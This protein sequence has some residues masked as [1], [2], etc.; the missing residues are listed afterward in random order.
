MIT[1]IKTCFKCGTEKTVA[2]FYKHPKMADGYLSKCKEC[3]K[4]D[5]RENRG[6]KLEYYREYDRS[7]GS[8]PTRVQ[9]RKEYAKTDACKTSVVKSRIRYKANNPEKRKAHIITGNA[10]RDGTLVNPGACWE[11]GGGGKI[12]AHHADYSS[13]LGVSWLCIPCHTT[14][15]KEHKKAQ[16]LLNKN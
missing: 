11:C 9:A 14:L 6:D 16:R 4:K 2:D 10:I 15:H 12:H 3:T 8:T 5:V 13:P 1:T 7:R